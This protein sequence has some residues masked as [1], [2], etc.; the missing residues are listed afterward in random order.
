LYIDDLTD[1]YL[2]LF[3]SDSKLNGESFTIGPPNGITIREL[4]LQIA[5]KLNWDGMI[6]WYTREIR[7]GEIYYLNSSNKKITKMTGWKPKTSLDE[8]LDK[9]IRYWQS[10]LF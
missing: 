1:L 2:T 7:D 4:A 6:N 3:K 8:G 10:K 5:H 9:T